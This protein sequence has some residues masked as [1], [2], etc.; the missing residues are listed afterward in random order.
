[1]LCYRCL[2]DHFCYEINAVIFIYQIVTSSSYFQLNWLYDK[3][4]LTY[5][6]SILNFFFSNCILVHNIRKMDMLAS[7]ASWSSPQTC[8]NSWLFEFAL[9]NIQKNGHVCIVWPRPLRN[10]FRVFNFFYL[11][12]VLSAKG[13]ACVSS[14]NMSI[15]RYIWVF[16]FL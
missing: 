9:C 7:N 5:D 15:T 1:M 14:V 10:M 2:G 16:N 6:Q 12:R 13:H 3:F 8:L 11:Q 4:L